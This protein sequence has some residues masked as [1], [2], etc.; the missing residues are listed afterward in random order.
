MLGL[1]GDVVRSARSLARPGPHLL[2]ELLLFTI[3]PTT[4]SV[5]RDGR[6]RSRET[7]ETSNFL[8]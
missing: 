5:G 7:E 2:A 4:L 3:W 1:V 8:E 6:P